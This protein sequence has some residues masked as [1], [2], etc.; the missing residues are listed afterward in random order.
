MGIKRHI[1]QNIIDAIYTEPFGLTLEDL[2]NKTG[3]HRATLQKYVA[4]L[5]SLG[6]IYV[7]RLGNYSLIFPRQIAEFIRYDYPNALLDAMLYIMLEKIGE[8]NAEE[9]GYQL[10][11]LFSKAI[12]STIKNYVQLLKKQLRNITSVYFPTTSLKTRAKIEILDNDRVLRL[13]LSGI[14]TTNTTLTIYCNFLKGYIK[15]ILEELEVPIASIS[16]A[17]INNSKNTCTF[18]MILKENIEKIIMN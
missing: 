8:Q 13:E 14:E 18:I 16:I 1:L 3:H 9:I 12:I 5:E 2:V 4:Y 15:G 11:K 7:R 17:D 6:L 10:A